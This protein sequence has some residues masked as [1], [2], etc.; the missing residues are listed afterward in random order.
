MLVFTLNALGLALISSAGKWKRKF[1]PLFSKRISR[2]S[3]DILQ[4]YTN[5]KSNNNLHN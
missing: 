3:I 5:V 1:F 4:A 2:P